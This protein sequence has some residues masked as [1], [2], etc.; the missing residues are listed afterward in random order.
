MR[1]SEQLSIHLRPVL[2]KTD[3]CYH[4]YW[5]TKFANK[6]SKFKVN[7]VCWTP[8]IKTRL[9]MRHYDPSGRLCTFSATITNTEFSI[10]NGLNFPQLFEHDWSR[11]VSTPTLLIHNFVNM[12][13]FLTKP[14]PIERRFS[15]LSIGTG[16]VE[17]TFMLGK[18]WTH[19]VWVPT[20]W[21]PSLI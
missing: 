1:G 18:L 3:H 10:P 6:F 9:K 17:N 11:F 14:V 5:P 8:E 16:F 12:D 20:T 7:P 15:G 4:S 2:L 21:D 19:I 13:V